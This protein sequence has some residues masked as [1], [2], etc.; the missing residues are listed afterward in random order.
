MQILFI[1]DDTKIT[2]FVSQG[3][4]EEGYG[5]VIAKEGDTGLQKALNEPFDLI[6]LDLMLP[7]LDGLSLCRQL[8]QQGRHT[9]IIMLTARDSVENRVQGLDAGADD[10][11][12]KPFSFSELLARIRALDRRK[13]SDNAK[14]LELGGIKMDLVAHKVTFLD[15]T[16]DLTSREFALL[17]LFMRRPGHVLTRTIIAESVW[18]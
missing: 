14:N 12:V 9:P 18:G 2:K 1:E 4:R 7:N 11:L 6:I 17:H 10:Y 15:K 8:R 3:L 13:R 16:V 5:V